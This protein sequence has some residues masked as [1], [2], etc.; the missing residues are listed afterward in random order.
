MGHQNQPREGPRCPDASPSYG[1]S[2]SAPTA[3]ASTLSLLNSSENAKLFAPPRD[4]PPKCIRC[5]VVG[6]GGILNG[7]RQGPNIDAHDYVFR[8]EGHGLGRGG[9]E[10]C[11][12]GGGVSPRGSG[13]WQQ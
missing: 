5:A 1:C 3:I 7:S 13:L 9:R 8:Y 10:S 6:N 11:P 12:E 2:P 4:S